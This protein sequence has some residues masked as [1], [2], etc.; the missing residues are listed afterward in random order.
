MKEENISLGKGN[1]IDS[2]GWMRVWGKEREYQMGSGDKNGKG[3]RIGRNSENS[4][5]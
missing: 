3:G 5:L 4:H 1:I 2:K